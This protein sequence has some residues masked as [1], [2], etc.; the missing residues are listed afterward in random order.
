[1]KKILEFIRNN[2]VIS[3]IVIFVIILICICIFN[4][5]KY[6]KWIYTRSDAKQNKQ[7]KQNK[8]MKKIGG[9]DNNNNNSD[10]PII[11]E[12]KINTSN[13]KRVRFKN[14]E[15]DEESDEDMDIENKKENQREQI[16]VDPEMLK[17]N[18]FGG[19]GVKIIDAPSAKTRM[20]ARR[21]EAPIRISSAEDFAS[22]SI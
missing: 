4:K 14:E 1:M 15:S 2:L 13:A 5:I 8:K 20:P 21:V 3:F 17:N 11:V 6:G 22:M 7:N 12:P 19:E 10:D 16:F 9:G 18:P